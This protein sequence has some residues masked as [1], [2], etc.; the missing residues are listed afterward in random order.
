M[1]NHYKLLRNFTAEPKGLG[2]KLELSAY[3][4]PPT[5]CNSKF[6]N[7]MSSQTIYLFLSRYFCVSGTG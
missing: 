4:R 5:F 3:S 7:E 6:E 1:N 2:L